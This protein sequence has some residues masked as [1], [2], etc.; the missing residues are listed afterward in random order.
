MCVCVCVCPTCSTCSLSLCFSFPAALTAWTHRSECDML[1]CDWL[2]VSCSLAL[3]PIQWWGYSDAKTFY[4]FPSRPV[5]LFPQIYSLN[6]YSHTKYGIWHNSKSLWITV[7]HPA[8]VLFM[9]VLCVLLSLVWAVF[10]RVSLSVVV[11]CF[12]VTALSAAFSCQGLQRA[13][14]GHFLTDRKHSRN[15]RNRQMKLNF[16]KV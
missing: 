14:G 5:F 1:H 3:S 11:L 12:M 10:S 13:E 7:I 16:A 6:L 9:R 15:I 8:A 4:F 2:N